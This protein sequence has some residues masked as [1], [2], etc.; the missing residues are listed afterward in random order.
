MTNTLRPRL[1]GALPDRA[2][3]CDE[4]FQAAGPSSRPEPSHLAASLPAVCYQLATDQ[5]AH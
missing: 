5:H 2:G 3:Q 1:S 4:P